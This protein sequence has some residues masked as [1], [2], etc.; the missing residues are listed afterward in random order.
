MTDS[1]TSY[2]NVDAN[3]HPDTESADKEER[4]SCV[5]FYTLLPL[6]ITACIGAAIFG[7]AISISQHLHEHTS[8]E[9]KA[10]NEIPKYKVWDTVLKKHVGPGQVDGVSINVVDYCGIKH[11]PSFDE[12]VTSWSTA[13]TTGFSK[14]QFLAFYVNAYNI[15]AI[16]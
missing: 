10:E 9:N 5:L 14:E 12:V 2:H 6:M 1:R 3:H 16:H 8:D 15:F 11:D 4:K 7:L 13:D